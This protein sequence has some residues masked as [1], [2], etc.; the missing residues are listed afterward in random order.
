MR[1]R[2]AEETRLAGFLCLVVLLAG[3]PDTFAQEQ[4]LVEAGSPMSYLANSSDPDVGLDWTTDGFDDTEWLG[5][6][7][8]VGYDVNGSAANL[9]STTVPAGTL[10]V[11]TRTTFY[12]SSVEQVTSLFAGADYDDGYAFWINGVEVFRSPEL[13]A[14]PLDRDS[15]TSANEPSNG[16]LPNYAP[17]HDI[18]RHTRGSAPGR[19]GSAYGGR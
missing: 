19:I 2:G 17:Y 9:I 5:G 12:V 16:A 7:Y 4:V 18:S 1:R 3:A 11:Y 10:S 15:A 8:G 14:G 6:T 13:A